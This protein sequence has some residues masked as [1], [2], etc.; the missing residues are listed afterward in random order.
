VV[1]NPENTG[2]STDPDWNGGYAQLQS[3]TVNITTNSKPDGSLAQLLVGSSSD[4][5]TLNV[6]S[7]LTVRGNSQMGLNS[8][9]L[10]TSTVNQTA[11]SVLFGGMAGDAN[12]NWFGRGD[13][14]SIYN[15]EGDS[16]ETAGTSTYFGYDGSS[17]F[18]FNQTG[19]SFTNTG[20]GNF[21]LASGAQ[22]QAQ[23]NI[24]GGSVVFTNYNG[25]VLVGDS[26]RGV[27]RQE[28]GDVF[29][30]G[31]VKLKNQASSSGL[32]SISGGSLKIGNYLYGVGGTFEVDG[33]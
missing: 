7:D 19:G 20:T 9:V 2:N 32:Y 1:G 28:G 18:I 17:R 10:T 6:G 26:G 23:F 25:Y 4:S 3:G 5:V 31:M 11:G 13:G 12:Y 15:L 8:G 21:V 27:I 30:N 22:S 33:S 14:V 24:Y 29:I 16:L